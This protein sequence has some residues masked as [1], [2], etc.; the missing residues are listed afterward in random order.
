MNKDNY[1]DIINLPHHTSLKHPRMSIYSRASQFA[2][3]SALI[4]YDE[5]V[6]E[7]SR[8]TSVKKELDDELRM[9]LDIRLQILFEHIKENPLVTFTYFLQDNNK[10]SGKYITVT[11]MIKKI[12]KVKQDIVL[13]NS[14]KIP[15]K[16]II[17]ISSNI[18]LSL[19]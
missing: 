2:P 4:G 5:M 10:K 3:F 7:A 8:I 11:G 12:D 6:K 19:E 13:T 18:F 15:I 1:L 14:I 17:N 9:L 16:D